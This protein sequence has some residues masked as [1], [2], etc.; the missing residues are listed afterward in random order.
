MRHMR[1]SSSLMKS[2]SVEL[3]STISCTTFGMLKAVMYFSRMRIV[4]G[5]HAQ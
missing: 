4:F 1:R 2:G 5:G 3:V